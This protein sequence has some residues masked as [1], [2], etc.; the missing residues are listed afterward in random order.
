MSA[1]PT[2]RESAAGFHDAECAQYRADLPYWLE[3]ATG[4]PGPVADLGAG[5]G[6]VAI[7]LADAGHEVVAIDIDPYLLQTLRE[8]AGDPA[9]AGRI[10]TVAADLT[11]IDEI[12]A[13]ANLRASL[14]IIPMQT[15]QLL[16]DSHQRRRALRAIAARSAPGA[17]L[18]I[19]FIPQVEPFDGRDLEVDLLPPDITTEGDWRFISTPRAVLQET[20]ESQIDMHR[21][22]Q[23]RTRADAPAG[24]ATDVVITLT[25]LQPGQLDD[26]AAAAGWQLDGIDTLAATDEHAGSLIAR[27]TLPNGE[28]H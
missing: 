17:T 10:S 27:F 20:P 9:S 26:E 19:A 24:S 14:T 7:P 25:P 11:A 1:L 18:A 8:R 4:T 28:E 3:L 5:T 6:R 15:I 13:L 16:E 23:I 22:R 12:P 21:R 2:P